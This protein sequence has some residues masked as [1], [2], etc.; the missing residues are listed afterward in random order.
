MMNFG[1]YPDGFSIFGCFGFIVIALYFLVI[2]F[3]IKYKKHSFMFSRI[4]F[5]IYFI[6]LIKLSL[7][8]NTSITSAN[9]AWYQPFLVCIFIE[10]IIYLIKKNNKSD[11]ENL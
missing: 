2:F 4:I 10:R 11:K 9:N 6:L 5:L 8:F 7:L 3:C 1:G